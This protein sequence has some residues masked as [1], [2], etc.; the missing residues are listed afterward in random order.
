[1]WVI[2]LGCPSD[3]DEPIKLKDVFGDVAEREESFFAL[4]AVVTARIL[5]PFL[6]PGHQAGPQ[7]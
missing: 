1:M 4:Q 6:R 5:E 2:R 3:L 7:G